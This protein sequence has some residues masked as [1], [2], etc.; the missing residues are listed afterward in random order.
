MN[1]YPSIGSRSRLGIVGSHYRMSRPNEV[2]PDG[3]LDWWLP[4]RRGHPLTDLRPDGPQVIPQG[5]RESD[6]H[7]CLTRHQLPSERMFPNGYRL[8]SRVLVTH[9]PEED[10]YRSWDAKR[11]RHF[12]GLTYTESEFPDLWHREEFYYA[13]VHP[14]AY[15]YND[16]Y[17]FYDVAWD[18][19]TRIMCNSYYRGN[20]RRK[21]GKVLRGLHNGRRIHSGSFHLLG[22]LQQL[23]WIGLRFEEGDLYRAV[24]EAARA[25]EEEAR[26]FGGVAHV[27]ELLRLAG[28]VRWAEFLEVVE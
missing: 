23:A 17:G 3:V 10:Y 13:D 20:S 2:A 7:Q 12:A 19:A 27:T 6:S 4:P 15:P 5:V 9:G 8:I 14:A 18:G 11:E 24:V 28:S 25:I 22:H 26:G 21:A 1:G 16:L